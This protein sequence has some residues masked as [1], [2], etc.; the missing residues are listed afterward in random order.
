MTTRRLLINTLTGGGSRIVGLLIGFVT[1]PLLVHDLGDG[2]FGLFVLVGAIVGYVGLLDFGIGPGLVRFFTEYDQ[3]ADPR[4]VDQVVSLATTFYLLMGLIVGSGLVVFAPWLIGRLTVSQSMR[5]TAET[6]I[7]IVFGYFILS[8]MVGVLTARLVSLHRM[9]ATSFIRVLGQVVYAALIVF[10]LPRSPTV[11]TAILLNVTQVVVT[12]MLSFIVLARVGPIRLCNPFSIPLPLIRKVMA[13]GGWMQI[14]SLAS[15]VTNQTDKIIVSAFISIQAV[16][17]YQ[18]GNRLGSVGDILPTQLLS[19]AMPNATVLGIADDPQALKR[20]YSEMTRYV[21]LLTVP[22]V[23]G[24]AAVA[25]PFILA[26]MGRSFPN[27]AFV[28]VGLSVTAGLSYLTGIG[29]TML[30][31]AGRPKYEAYCAIVGTVLNIVITIALA[32]TFGLRGIVTGTVLA[33][34]FYSICF[35]VLFHRRYPFGWWET[36]GTWLWRLLGAMMLSVGTVE[37]LQHFVWGGP[38]NRVDAIVQIIGYGTIFML[39]FILVLT[40]LGFWTRE[41]RDAANKV[42]RRFRLVRSAT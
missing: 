11:E 18:I 23:G 21:M 37:I 33:E 27:A 22:V 14:N 38:A 24:I 15:L 20:F 9:N 2:G 16:T 19:A 25:S 41:D 30:R 5:Q 31:A 39:V 7:F 13:F 12:G 10:V 34:M 26:W 6:S 1:T 40:A 32:P 3:K 17:P 28:A 8:C 36:V 29:T 35:L 42:L 4:G